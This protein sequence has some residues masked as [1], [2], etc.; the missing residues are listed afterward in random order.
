MK[1]SLEI[2]NKMKSIL[3]VIISHLLRETKENLRSLGISLLQQKPLLNYISF[4][5]HL[6]ICMLERIIFYNI[7]IEKSKTSILRGE[8]F[9]LFINE[10]TKFTHLYIHDQFDIL[11]LRPNVAFQ[12]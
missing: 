5:R 3:N 10:S 2:F 12:N 7:H 8:I 9:N 1:E 4:C 11:F 6:D